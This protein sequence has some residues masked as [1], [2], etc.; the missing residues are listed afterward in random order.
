MHVFSV[1]FKTKTVRTIDSAN[2]MESSNTGEI[3]VAEKSE[4][5]QQRWTTVNEST[6]NDKFANEAIADDS[7]NDLDYVL[8]E[9]GECGMQQMW[10]YVL[11][12]VPIALSAIY[13]ISFIVTGSSLDYRYVDWRMGLIFLLMC[14]E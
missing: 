3:G 14:G 1:K 9:I 7:D 11:I 10:K 5:E 4:N 12:F 8:S 13:A 6:A 2:S